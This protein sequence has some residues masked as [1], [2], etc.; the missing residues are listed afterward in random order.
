L[1]KSSWQKALA[2]DC[3]RMPLVALA[4]CAAAT[5]A[6][7]AGGG[8]PG[9]YLRP[10]VGAAATALGGAYTAMPDYFAAWWNPAALGFLRQ[11]RLAGGSG[12]RSLGRVDAFGAFDFPIPPR[13]GMGL[14]VLYRGDPSL[15]GLYGTDERLLP[16]AAYTTLTFKGAL[17]Y[18]V[19]RKL[20]VGACI[21]GMYQSLPTY[22]GEDGI[23][24]VD[25]T[26]IGAID[27]ALMYHLSKSW[28]GALLV[29]NCGA[30]M[31]WQMGDFS[32]L[33]SDRPLPEFV[34]AAS[35]SGSFGGKPLL[36]LVDARGYLVDGEWNMLDRP[37][38]ILGTGAEWR[39]WDNFYV[40]A[41]IGSIALNG[42][43]LS[44]SD[45]YYGEAAFQITAGFSYDLARVRKG[46]WLN[47]G[48][49]TDKVWA[50][51]DQQLDVT[52]A[53]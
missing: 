25:A 46:L 2:A 6:V 49:A 53:F 15:D 14:M 45:R 9:A 52:L 10:P 50:G 5:V 38:A 23:D 22:G 20:S 41:G 48:A 12:L 16:A 30:R 40:R 21:S 42:I 17:S 44:D 29:K 1:E 37:E 7:A 3:V 19:N 28:N 39:R 27:L 36:W 35:W 34:A 8:E 33:V 4:L 31:E 51:I 11:Q 26:G 47:Y 13:V 43:I 24:N 18:Y 32:P